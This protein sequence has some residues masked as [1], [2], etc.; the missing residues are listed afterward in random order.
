ME[1]VEI[2]LANSLRSR[3][4]NHIFRIPDGADLAP[5]LIDRFKGAVQ[6]NDLAKSG[7]PESR[8]L[9]RGRRELNR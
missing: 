2:E 9:E 7:P 1:T 8:G 6:E 4:L 5:V 3:A